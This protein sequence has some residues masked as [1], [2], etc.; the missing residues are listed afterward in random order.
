M[1]TVHTQLVITARTGRSVRPQRIRQSHVDW[2]DVRM[3]D[4][5]IAILETVNR[6]RLITSRQ[7]ERL[8]FSTLANPHSRS[9]ARGRVLQRLV[10]WGV[11]APLPRRIGGSGRGSAPLV[12]ALDTTGRRLLASRQLG[13]GVLKP[14]V[15]FPGPPGVRTVQHTLAIAELYTCL[16]EQTRNTTA[17]LVTFETEP[18]CWWPDG[19]GSHLKPDALAV[20]RQQKRRDFWW[21]EMDMATESLATIRRKALT[22]LD[23]LKRG[24]E[25]PRKVTPWV[26]FAAPDEKRAAL[27]RQV[28][29]PLPSD[30]DE[31]LRATTHAHC[32]A[33]MTAV[34][35]E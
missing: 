26:I 29:E 12:L 14:Q 13:A 9:V 16:T 33:Y 11:L 25:G 20:L 32:A 18:A 4:R 2:V 24:Q 19:L 6:L 27:I 17:E 10:G 1:T 34:L 5:D 8:L 15:R 28:I 30:H 31:L 3:S 21:I 23:F 35:K 7:L 22:Y